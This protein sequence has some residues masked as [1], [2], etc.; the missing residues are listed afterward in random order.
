MLVMLGDKH[1]ENAFLL[2]NH[3]NHAARGDPSQDTL[4][5]IPLLLMMIKAFLS[6]NVL[7]NPKLVDR[8][9]FRQL[10]PFPQVSN[11]PPPLQGR[12]PMVAS[13]LDWSKGIIPPMKYGD[14]KRTLKLGLIITHGIQISN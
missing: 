13:L 10:A 12:H 6:G 4:V 7:H 8:N 11:F 1:T 14:G 5:R 3:S 9:A 2:C